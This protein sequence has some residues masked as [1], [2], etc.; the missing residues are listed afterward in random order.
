[1]ENLPPALGAQ[2]PHPSQSQYRPDH[3]GKQAVG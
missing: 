2:A 1:M 3:R